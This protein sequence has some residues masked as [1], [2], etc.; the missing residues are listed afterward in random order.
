MSETHQFQVDVQGTISIYRNSSMSVLT[1]VNEFV[2][3]SLDAGGKEIRI[4]ESGGDLIIKDNGEGFSNFGD[5]VFLGK[6]PKANKGQIGRHG[7]GMKAAC[8][9]FSSSTT[10]RSQG[11]EMVVPWD[12][13]MDG[14][15]KP[16]FEVTEGPVTE[17]TEIIL[18]DF[19]KLRSTQALQ[20]QLLAKTYAMLIHYKA[21]EIKINGE[22]LVM[23][24]FPEYGKHV[25]TTVQWRGRKARVIGGTY[26]TDD[27]NRKNW[28][29]YYAYYNGRLI[30]GGVLECGR[31]DLIC[32]NFA[33]HLYL[34]DGAKAWKLSTH[35]DDV[36]ELE[37]FIE[38]VFDTVTEPD[39]EAAAKDAEIIELKEIE[40]AVNEALGNKRN[41]KRN[42][43]NHKKEGSV[44]PKHTP[45]KRI[46]TNHHDAEGGY[47]SDEIPSKKSKGVQFSF[48]KMDGCTLGS[49]ERSKGSRRSWKFNLNNSFVDAFKTDKKCI[50]PLVLFFNEL[51]NA[52]SASELF[53]EETLTSVM[54]KTGYHL[55]GTEENFR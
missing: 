50:A 29:G 47:I 39:L 52:T 33:Y 35:K 19:D 17:G 18:H 5:A 25:D 44:A 21:A 55:D 30:R 15:I 49:C 26:K 16:Q 40:D 41:G 9:K 53:A 24:P 23:P 13:I 46:R 28:S 37:E 54:E 8:I 27:P 7:V 38:Y 45:R 4:I 31:G 10:V 14:T 11:K 2:D 22:P 43:S 34:Q 36:R 20:P 48:E 3:N 1:A 6:S 32:S 42:N 12:D 51:C